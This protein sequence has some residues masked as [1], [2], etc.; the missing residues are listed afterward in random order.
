MRGGNPGPTI[1]VKR[2]D[3][4]NFDTFQKSDGKVTVTTHYVVSRDGKSLTAT[5]NGLDGNGKKYINVS[6]YDKQM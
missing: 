3:A 1:A 4:F 5:A 6:V 2:T